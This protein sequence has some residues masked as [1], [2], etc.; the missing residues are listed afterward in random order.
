MTGRESTEVKV[1]Y[2]K[3]WTDPGEAEAIDDRF[4][5]LHHD[6]STRSVL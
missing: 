6:L 2:E 1:Q 5:D 4:A 3:T